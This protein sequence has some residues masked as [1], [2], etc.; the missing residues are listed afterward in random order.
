MIRYFLVLEGNSRFASYVKRLLPYLVTLGLLV[1]F[2]Q[3]CFGIIH[4]FQENHRIY[5]I[6]ES[7]QCQIMIIHIQ[8]AIFAF[9]TF[10]MYNRRECLPELERVLDAFMQQTPL[11][12]SECNIAYIRKIEYSNFKIICPV[13]VVIVNIIVGTATGRIFHYLEYRAKMMMIILELSCITWIN[14]ITQHGIYYY[15]MIS[16][17]IRLKMKAVCNQ[18]QKFFNC[19]EEVNH[20]KFI[21]EQHLKITQ[22]IQAANELFS[23]YIFLVYCT[24]IPMILM[25]LCNIIDGNSDEL[26]WFQVMYLMI[27]T[28]IV[29]AVTF[30]AGFLSSSAHQAEKILFKNISAPISMRE[31]FQINVFQSRMNAEK[32]GYTCLDLFVVSNDI[33]LKIISGLISYL[34]MYLQM[35]HKNKI[36]SNNN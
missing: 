23:V 24:F 16:L 9:C 32:I 3:L 25:G 6:I 5:D 21:Q 13:V 19:L 1:I 15:V 4:K 7:Q 33:I 30:V 36:K 29:T 2:G 17:V 22:M 31:A 18:L 10:Y 14:L 26:I 12:T 8:F 34:L 35:K 27:A 20:F 11:S 28:V